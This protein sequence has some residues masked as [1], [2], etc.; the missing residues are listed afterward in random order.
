M[1]PI[2]HKFIPCIV[3]FLF[4]CTLIYAD[5]NLTT[6]FFFYEAGCPHC[7]RVDKFLQQRIKKNYAVE[8]KYYE[9][10]KPENAKLLSH[11][12]NIH[13]AE[14]RTP[15]VF[16]GDTLIQGDK[17][18]SL[19]DIEAAVRDALRNN[20]G[21]PL[22]KI[23]TQTGLK[24]KLTI[25]AVIS[26]AAVDAINPCACA[27]L[28]LLLGTILI[29]KKSRKQAIN[30]G[31]AFTASTFISYLLMGVGLYFTIKIAGIQYYI[32]IG[33]AILAI[34]IGL[35]NMKDCFW[36]GKWISLEVPEAW[37]PKVKKITSGVTSI[38]G[39]FGV[40]FLV[41]IFLLPCSSG[42][43]IVIIGMLSNS[44]ARMQSV[45]LLILYNLIFILPFLI[46]TF[47]VGYGLT[48]TARVEKMRQE[49]VKKLHLVTGII[50][51]LIGVALI[52][53]VGTD[54]M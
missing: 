33:V 15:V 12:S 46:I 37:R 1:N 14:L 11:L 32:Y 2:S 44:A 51:C 45:F 48:T 41:S 34:I 10:H 53:I 26:A 20:I 39:A 13:N 29:V 38:P 49:K 19:M 43:Y 22:I 28:T 18:E 5:D 54:N 3:L 36:Y 31:L 23:T 6:L 42:P 40:G 27:I 7:A 25:P 30:A 16:V 9:V 17:R 50:M 4:K 52:V 24:H 8:I 35:I 21:S 47:A